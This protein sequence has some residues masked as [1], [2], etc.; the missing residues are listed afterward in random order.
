[1]RK[2]NYSNYN[3]TKIISIL[4]KILKFLSKIKTSDKLHFY[5]KVGELSEM[6]KKIRRDEMKE[7]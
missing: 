2:K 6:K 1:V 4:Y 7:S 5:N 3:T